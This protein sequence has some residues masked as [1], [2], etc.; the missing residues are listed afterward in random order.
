MKPSGKDEAISGDIRD[1]EKRASGAAISNL[2]SNET[3]RDDDDKGELDVIVVD[4]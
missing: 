1:A 3:G 4:D 2:D